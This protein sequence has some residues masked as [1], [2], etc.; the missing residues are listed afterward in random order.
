[1]HF[2]LERRLKTF[3]LLLTTLLS[4]GYWILIIQLS[5][6]YDFFVY[7][8]PVFRLIGHVSFLVISVNQNKIEEEDLELPLQLLIEEVYLAL[9]YFLDIIFMS[10]SLWTTQFIYT[11][12]FTVTYVLQKSMRFDMT[13]IEVQVAIAILAFLITIFGISTYYFI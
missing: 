11:P 3:Y 9:S 4:Y 10:P 13:T 8:I 5:K 12:I 6:K 2:A 7:L 1:M